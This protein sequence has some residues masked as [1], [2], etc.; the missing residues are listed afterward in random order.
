M[1]AEGGKH[2]QAQS[3]RNYPY[4][5]GYHAYLEYGKRIDRDKQRRAGKMAGA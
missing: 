5:L 4:A 3:N 1:G 2:D